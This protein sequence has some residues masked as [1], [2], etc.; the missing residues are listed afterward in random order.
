MRIDRV[1]M[2]DLTK[3]DLF[4]IITWT[5]MK[6]NKAIFHKQTDRS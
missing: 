6:S 1:I 2:I 4:K 3:C 5:N